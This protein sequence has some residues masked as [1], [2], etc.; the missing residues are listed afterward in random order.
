MYDQAAK[1]EFMGTVQSAM[2]AGPKHM[3]SVLLPA[4]GTSSSDI[5]L[6]RALRLH[7][8][9]AIAR[10]CTCISSISIAGFPDP[11]LKNQVL[12]LRGALLA[13]KRDHSL[14]AQFAAC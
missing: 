1:D 6:L 3:L 11:Y 8:A 14:G 4:V 13:S 7:A 12:L 10:G 5:T 9:P 2:M